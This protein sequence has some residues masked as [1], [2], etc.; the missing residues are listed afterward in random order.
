MKRM[1]QWAIS[2]IGVLEIFADKLK[3]MGSSWFDFSKEEGERL[4]RGGSGHLC[5][6]LP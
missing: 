4:V 3:E 2:F 5:G 6:H 1:G